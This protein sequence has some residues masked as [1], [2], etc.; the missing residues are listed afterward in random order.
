MN[1]ISNCLKSILGK[2]YFPNNLA[3]EQEHDEEIFM[4]LDK[5]I[6]NELFTCK[7]VM[8]QAWVEGF[9]RGKFEQTIEMIF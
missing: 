4:H 5:L 3:F 9:E 6:R 1:S 7:L 2:T 8:E